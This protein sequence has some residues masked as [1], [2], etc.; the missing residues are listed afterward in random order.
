MDSNLGGNTCDI[1]TAKLFSYFNLN[2]FFKFP[3]NAFIK[4][5]DGSRQS[6]KPE[7]L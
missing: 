6:L 1:A 7:D 4:I 3:R 2:K 5:P